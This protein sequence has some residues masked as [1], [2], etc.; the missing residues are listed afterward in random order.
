VLRTLI[1]DLVR[2]VFVTEAAVAAL[3]TLRF[4]VDGSH[5]LLES[6]HL[7]SFHA[8]SA[9][10]NAG[11]SVFEGGLE[12]FTTDWYTSLVIAATFIVGGIGFP[13]VFELQRR[14][15]KPG[16]WSLHTKVSLTVTAFLLSGGTVMF[17]AVE[18]TNP[19]TIGPLGLPDKLLAS[20]FQSA[21]ARTA[22][23]NTL[24][25]GSL[26]NATVMVLVLLMVIGASSA[27]T[28]GGIK[29]ST[30]AV[31]VRA[32]LAELQGD[33]ATALFN[34]QVTIGQQRQCHR[35]AS[36]SPCAPIRSSM[37][38]R[39]RRRLRRWRRRPTGPRRP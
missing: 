16:S 32:W 22:G 31:V 8:V 9:F 12:R 28:G 23:F 19:S 35:Y 1:R 5:S 27:S 18:W 33:R 38:S 3:L 13:V 17:A 6:A 20:F 4:A 25:M 37:G 21:T 30:L 11:F 39:R 34:R 24:P 15:R 29:T 26:R 14:W 7:G 10:N 2:F 36:P